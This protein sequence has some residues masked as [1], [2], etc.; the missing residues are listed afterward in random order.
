[1][2]VKRTALCFTYNKLQGATVE[3]LILLLNDVEPCKL[4]KM[5]VE[6]LY[7]GLSR[8]EYG[9]HLAVW[10]ASRVDLTHLYDKKASDKLFAW[11][12][13]Y[14]SNGMW[15]DEKIQLQA[16]DDAFEKMSKINA[17]Y[18]EELAAHDEN[19]IPSARME[20]FI[21]CLNEE[22]R[23]HIMS[24]TGA[25]ERTQAVGTHFC[26]NIDQ[27]TLKRQLTPYLVC[28]FGPGWKPDGWVQ[29]TLQSRKAFLVE[30]FSEQVNN[31]QVSRAR[32]ERMVRY[33]K[34]SSTSRN[35]TIVCGTNEDG[36]DKPNDEL[37][38]ELWEAYIQKDF[39]M[40][41]G[42]MLKK[43]G[44]TVGYSTNDVSTKAKVTRVLKAEYIS[45]LKRKHPEQYLVQP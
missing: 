6:K 24:I 9:K 20:E 23:G 32:L 36:S 13:H 25:S 27:C 18:K 40:S 44:K 26:N 10:P 21:T 41:R 11:H 12:A 8:V 2:R 35:R 4:G 3:R 19:G 45:F 43:L 14:D 34:E 5:C 15:M 39:Q 29:M 28:L 16:V 1:M 42:D 17:G 30:K 31:S 38:R 7:V 33:H 37:V 22:Q